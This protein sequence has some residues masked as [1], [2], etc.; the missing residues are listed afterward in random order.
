ML[1]P[2]INFIDRYLNYIG[3]IMAT[4]KPFKTLTL[5][6][7]SYLA[8]FSLIGHCADGTI[9]LPKKDWINLK[10]GWI[11]KAS[12]EDN[13]NL[14]TKPL[15]LRYFRNDDANFEMQIM[16]SKPHIFGTTGY[17]CRSELMATYT[18]NDEPLGFLTQSSQ[19]IGYVEDG[20]CN[21][22]SENYR[23]GKHISA[24]QNFDD[25]LLEKIILELPN[26]IENFNNAK[27]GES[28]NCPA[29]KNAVNVS[30]ARI[31]DKDTKL[32]VQ[33]GYMVLYNASDD[34]GASIHLISDGDE[35]LPLDCEGDMFD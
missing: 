32:Y 31:Y 14:K 9:K 17:L 18:L 6:A 16:Y 2:C 33:S 20:D 25:A 26:L 19:I 11:E 22:T 24:T 23:S 4:N 35:L 30:V 10:D 27:V 34:V 15:A 8:V 29:M 28:V 12:S 1:F 13:F 5:V 21:I 7:C 3:K